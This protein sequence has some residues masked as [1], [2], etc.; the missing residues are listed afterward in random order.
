ML[1]YGVFLVF[2]MLL[3]R[4]VYRF[5]MI[6]NLSLILDKLFTCT[7]CYNEYMFH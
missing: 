2:V 6:L 3:L 1:V 4:I 7:L 5:R